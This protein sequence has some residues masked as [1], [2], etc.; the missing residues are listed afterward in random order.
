MYKFPDRNLTKKYIYIKLGAY[1]LFQT[2][3]I[4]KIYTCSNFRTDPM[5]SIVFG[6]Q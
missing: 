2:E 3:I 1:N 5:S 6:A 4:N